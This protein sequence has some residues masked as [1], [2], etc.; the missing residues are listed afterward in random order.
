MQVS[1]NPEAARILLGH[2]VD[3]DIYA[4]DQQQTAVGWIDG[5]PPDSLGNRKIRERYEE[6]TGNALFVLLKR[7]LAVH[8][9]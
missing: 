9:H 7:N 4:R 2:L 5:G 1:E 8:K 6:D 3:G